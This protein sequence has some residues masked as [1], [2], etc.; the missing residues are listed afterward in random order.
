ME[1]I[2]YRGGFIYLRK[3]NEIYRGDAADDTAI[4][5][6][7]TWEGLKA[8]VKAFGQLSDE[9]RVSCLLHHLTRIYSSRINIC[10]MQKV[11]YKIH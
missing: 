6:Y 7:S 8:S 5:W 3:G 10:L 4:R 11:L 1:T 9:S 2:G